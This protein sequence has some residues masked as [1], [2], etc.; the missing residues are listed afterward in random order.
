MIQLIGV[1]LS[2][3]PNYI[4]T[5]KCT[6]SHRVYQTR[7]NATA[8]HIFFLR[9]R[10]SSFFARSLARSFRPS[11]DNWRGGKLLP[12]GRTRAGCSRRCGSSCQNHLAPLF[13]NCLSCSLL[14]LV[15]AYV[16]PPLPLFLPLRFETSASLC[17]NLLFFPKGSYRC[18]YN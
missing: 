16:Q 5:C 13:A 9:R 2:P 14:S 7:K 4:Y 8:G 3:D 17:S 15:H 12:S 1:S 18:F 6:M 11:G 10:P